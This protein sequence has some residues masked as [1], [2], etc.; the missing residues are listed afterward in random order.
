M[1]REISGVKQIPGE[2][3]RRWV[4]CESMD[5]FVWTNDSDEIVSYQL[6]Y[7]KPHPEKALSWSLEKGFTH[8]DVDDG[9]RP[10][11]NPASTIHPLL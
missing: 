11:H 8:D 7:N 4:F 2:L 6:S 10:G 3:C 5:L 9:S 1:F